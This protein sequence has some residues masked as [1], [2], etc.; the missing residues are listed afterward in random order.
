MA[1]LCPLPWRISW[2]HRQA[3]LF[4]R[5]SLQPSSPGRI[6]R[7]G[8]TGCR[9]SAG[10]AGGQRFLSY[11]SELRGPRGHV[12]WRGGLRPWRVPSPSVSSACPPPLLRAQG[13]PAPPQ[14][15]GSTLPT[16]LS[17]QSVMPARLRPVPA[18]SRR[19]KLQGILADL[20]DVDG[21]P[22]KVT[23]PPPGTPQPRPHEG[24]QPLH[25]GPILRAP[26]QREAAETKARASV[27][28][29][30]RP[31]LSL[32]CSLPVPKVRLS[33]SVSLSFCLSCPV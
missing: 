18:E 2:G 5:Q 33:I 10:E 12:G 15:Q 6:G 29:G 4:L 23:G 21:L 32:V 9:P 22:P 8:G 13:S 1:R 20:R 26:R 17:G 24:K 16:W 27:S 25:P 3:Q 11:D 31:S 7:G 14:W 30:S 28:S 19:V